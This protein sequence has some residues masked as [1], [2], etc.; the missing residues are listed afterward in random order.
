MLETYGERMIIIIA[1][2]IAFILPEPT[3]VERR[4]YDRARLPQNVPLEPISVFDLSQK[5]FFL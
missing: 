2:D 3:V 4:Y 5:L 1:Q